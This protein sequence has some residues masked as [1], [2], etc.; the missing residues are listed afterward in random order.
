MARKV[1]VL[2]VTAHPDD[3]EIL[4]GGTLAKYA[5]RGDDVTICHACNGNKGHVEIPP[6]KLV[7]I[8]WAEADKAA[9]IIG[10]RHASLGIPD[11]GVA[12]NPEVLAELA[13]VIREVRPTVIFTHD[14][15]DYMPD[16]SDLGRIV[17]KAS[18]VAT[19][20]QEE[21]LRGKVYSVVPP[22]YFL[23]TIM[24]VGFVPEEYVDVT[25]HFDEKRRMLKC[26]KSQVEWLRDHDG[27]D[28]VED[29]TICSRYRGLQCGVKYAEAFR[30]HRVWQRSAPGR[31]LP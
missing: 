7:E 27:I 20:P 13:S 24:G 12:E 10:A 6:E 18:F 3:M 14:P 23:D 2:A 21:G 22:V 30:R 1:R 8:R 9:R 29:M 5:A 19:L 17:L 31:L 15:E 26:H 28:V 4:C 16:H 25:D 11:L